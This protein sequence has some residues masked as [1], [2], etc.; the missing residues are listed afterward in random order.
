[1]RSARKCIRQHSEGLDNLRDLLS[2]AGLWTLVKSLLIITVLADEVPTQRYSWTSWTLK[3]NASAV[4]PIS[5]SADLVKQ[6]KLLKL[7]YSVRFLGLLSREEAYYGCPQLLPMRA[8]LW[9]FVLSTNFPT[10]LFVDLSQGTNI[11]VD[12]GIT[13]AYITPLGETK[14]PPPKSLVDWLNVD[15]AV[16]SLELYSFQ[17]LFR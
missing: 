14:L 9:Q 17:M 3:R 4:W 11:M 12:G 1:M 2:S 13:A 7:Y 16:Y 6:W 8:A 15:K 10:H 5:Q